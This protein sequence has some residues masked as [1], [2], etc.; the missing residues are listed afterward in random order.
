[1][2]SPYDFAVPGGVNIHVASVAREM[3]RTGHEV[4][5]LAPS[6]Q[7]EPDHDLI[8][9]SR[10]IVTLVFAGS[11]AGIS[12]SP[13]MYGRVKKLLSHEAFDVI[14]L[15]EPL[16]P[17]LPP[18][19]LRHSSLAPNATRIATFHSYRRRPLPGAGSPIFRATLRKLDGLIAVS[20]SARSYHGTYFP[21]DYHVIPNG[22]DIGRFGSA[23]PL[24]EYDDGRPNILFVGRLDRRK[25][26]EHL[27]EAFRRLKAGQPSAR[28][29][30]AGAFD[31]DDRAPFER[32]VARWGLTDVVFVGPVPSD[33]L[34]RYY[35]TAH[36]FCAPA[37]GF[38]SFGMVLLEAMAAGCA[39]VASDIP[40]YRTVLSHGQQGLAVPPRDARAL[41][42]ALGRLLDNPAERRALS[43]AGRRK[44]ADYGWEQV[45]R[46]ILDFYSETHLHV[47]RQLGAGNGSAV[48]QPHPAAETLGQGPAPPA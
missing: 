25:G 24:P 47:R 26:F 1:M 46:R 42:R 38:E 40:G 6:S 31:A 32:R 10:N 29:L 15:H 36:I 4:R 43:E 44:A 8:R 5:I 34:A 17:A 30:V 48:S 23:L 20:E 28:L 19:V 39:V 27:L 16:A 18:F 35:R 7:A 41:E 33:M 11:R 14:H 2:V 37:T 3:R 45:T 22:V 21:G 13:L 12:L 9:V